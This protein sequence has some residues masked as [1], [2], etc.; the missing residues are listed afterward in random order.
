[1]EI[2]ASTINISS[3]FTNTV[4]TAQAPTPLSRSPVRTLDPE[5]FPVDW[6]GTQ[7]AM[8]AYGGVE[9]RN[10]SFLPAKNPEVMYFGLG[11]V[12]GSNFHDLFDRRVDTVIRFSYQTSLRRSCKNEN[13]LDVKI[14]VPGNT[15]IRLIPDY[16]TKIL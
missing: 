3:T 16:Y 7:E 6:R 10:Q 1:F 14:P 15:S 2:T 8:L 12:S 11:L 4:V 9:T 5:G 13:Q